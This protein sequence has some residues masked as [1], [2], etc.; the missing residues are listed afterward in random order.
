[1]LKSRNED[2]YIEHPVLV[3]SLV[4]WE[5]DFCHNYDL[6]EKNL[7][8]WFTNTI[9]SPFQLYSYCQVSNCSKQAINNYFLFVSFVNVEEKSILY[10]WEPERIMNR[11]Q[12]VR[13]SEVGK[14]SEWSQRSSQV[15]RELEQFPRWIFKQNF[16][17]KLSGS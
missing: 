13:V 17:F 4:T 1:M 11:A 15:I 6:H 5:T 2:A 9:A 10:Y 14:E 3:Q 16:S 12:K 7:L 8:I